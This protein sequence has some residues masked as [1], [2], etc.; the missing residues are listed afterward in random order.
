MDLRGKVPLTRH[1]LDFTVPLPAST[2]KKR[3]FPDK[4]ALRECVLEMCAKGMSYRQIARE[5]GVHWTRVGKIIQS[6]K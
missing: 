6:T 3:A 4:A 1:K 5:V 2:V